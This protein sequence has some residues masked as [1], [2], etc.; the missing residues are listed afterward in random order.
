MKAKNLKFSVQ[1]QLKETR[2]T[3]SEDSLYNKDLSLKLRLTTIV[4]R[5][6]ESMK[7]LQNMYYTQFFNT[8]SSLISGIYNFPNKID[9]NET[10]LSTLPR[11]MMKN[12]DVYEEIFRLLQVHPCYIKMIIDQKNKTDDANKNPLVDKD[13]NKDES[14]YSMI[15]S[16][17][18]MKYNSESNQRSVYVILNIMRHIIVS[19][20]NN[21]L[22]EIISSKNL[23]HQLFLM[24]F[25]AQ[26]SNKKFAQE[27][28][29][30][31]AEHFIK[32]LKKL[33]T[34]K[35]L[36]HKKHK[37]T[38]KD[39]DKVSN[40]ETE[41]NKILNKAEPEFDRDY[42]EYLYEF[43]S[44][45]L[46]E[47]ENKYMAMSNSNNNFITDE[48]RWLISFLRKQLVLEIFKR[49]CSNDSD[50]DE[51]NEITENELLHFQKSDDIS[52]V[53]LKL[54]FDPIIKEL[55][56]FNTKTDLAKLLGARHCDILE[57]GATYKSY[58]GVFCK[59]VQSGMFKDPSMISG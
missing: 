31:M 3:L 24:I 55:Q 17:F 9:R 18:L 38:P 30:I 47:M 15:N 41:E 26:P 34:L 32:F 2:L 40:I 8:E 36:K 11:A 20:Q 6:H 7:Y 43:I 10:I 14:L 29:I 1:E 28:I 54:I 33:K 39:T 45:M 21:E 56:K 52:K 51:D 12:K 42:S 48:I 46:V 27:T 44:S 53:L 25:N 4:K 16:I 58:M 37:A 19:K 49:R 23:F 22:H 57:D 35:K 13:L 50:S 59:Y 5:L